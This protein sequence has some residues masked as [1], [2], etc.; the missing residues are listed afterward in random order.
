[1][2]MILP[3][4]NWLPVLCYL[5]SGGCYTGFLITRKPRLGRVATGILMA[6]LVVHFIALLQR[7]SLIQSVPYKDLYGSMSLFAWELGLIYLVLEARHK[8]RSMSIF[9]LP[10]MIVLQMIS[11][12]FQTMPESSRWTKGSLFAFHVNVTMLAYSA[13]AISFIAS[14][15]YLIQ[16]RALRNRRPGRWMSLLP[17]L[18]SLERV[19]VTS[20][21]IGIGALFI[22]ILTGAMWA[23]Q[24][25][26]EEPQ[27]WDAKITWSFLVLLIYSLYLFLQ[28]R[29]G[30]RGQRSAW[31]AV[32]G[33]LIVLFSYT[34]VNLFFSRLH[35]FF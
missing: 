23:R 26:R 24:A 18:N 25:W 22:G 29:R 12:F 5:L 8:Q 20:V 9:L 6:G 27:Q 14:T 1:M 3:F 34:M 4:L 11:I 17:P 19:N 33:F 28:K 21:V 31:V 30:W 15:M 32:G 35:A 10:I 13:F 7:A 16:H 2:V